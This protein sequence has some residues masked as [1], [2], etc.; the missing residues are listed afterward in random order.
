MKYVV[1][2]QKAFGA[3]ANPESKSFNVI[4]EAE[5][6]ERAMKRSKVITKLLKITE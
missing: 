3:G 4:K 5:W 1:E 6:F 2:Y